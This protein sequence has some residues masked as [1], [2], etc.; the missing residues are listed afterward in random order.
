[1][2]NQTV[3]EIICILDKSGSMQTLQA[4]T[5]AGLNKFIKNLQQGEI[6]QGPLLYSKAGQP[7]L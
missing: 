7:L 1:M 2:E 5:L 4:E 3:T 6:T